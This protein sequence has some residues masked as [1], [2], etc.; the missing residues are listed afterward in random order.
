MDS[1]FSIRMRASYRGLHVSGA[2]RI[3][4]EKELSNVIF[5]L[6]K[7]PKKYDF[8]SLK[9]EKIEDVEFI[10]PLPVKSFFM[11]SVEEGRTFAKKLLMDFGIRKDIVDNIFYLIST[12]PYNGRNMRGAMLIDIDTGERLEENQEKGIRTIKV[13]WEDREYASNVLSSYPPLRLTSRSLDALALVSK[14]VKCGVLAEVCWSD[15]PDYSTGYVVINGIYHRIEPLK[16]VGDPFGGRAYFI[17]AKDIKDIINCL[18]E[19]AFL[20]KV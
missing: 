9:T 10:S 13:D 18:R 16:R 3:C 2:E 1:Y 8:I 20:I 14:N 4:K 15:D 6:L 11:K 12:G 5:E 17:K 7:R 19:R